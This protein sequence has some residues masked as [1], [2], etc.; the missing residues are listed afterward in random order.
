M[1]ISNAHVRAFAIAGLSLSVLITVWS[2]SAFAEAPDGVRLGTTVRVLVELPPQ[3][4]VI[5]VPAEAI[6]G[7]DRLYKV[8]DGRMQMVAVER[9]GETL[10][11]NGTSQV[12]VRSSALQS[13]DEIIVTKLS[14]AVDGLLVRSPGA[15]PTDRMAR[16]PSRP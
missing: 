10:A 1:P 13:D 15:T 11:A 8:V 14:N 4:D 2:G 7:S 16:K 3:S 9:V 6:Y 5:A 12:I